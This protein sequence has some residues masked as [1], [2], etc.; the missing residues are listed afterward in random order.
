MFEIRDEDCEVWRQ[1]G[2]EPGWRARH[3]PTGITICT[4]HDFDEPAPGE[5]LASLK[6]TVERERLNLHALN[7]SRRHMEAAIAAGKAIFNLWPAPKKKRPRYVLMPEGYTPPDILARIQE[8]RLTQ[9]PIAQVAG[10]DVAQLP[11]QENDQE[12]TDG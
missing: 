6:R 9:R 8:L 3:K 2:S 11:R 5:M 4:S 1:S 12:R 7:E 10:A